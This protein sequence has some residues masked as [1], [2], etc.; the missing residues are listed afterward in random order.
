MDSGGSLKYFS[1]DDC[2]HREYKRWKQWA[3][4]KILVMDRLPKEARGA[5]IWTL[6]QGK[7]LEVVEHLTPDQYQV[8][9]GE[10]V[11]FDLLDARWPQKDKSDEIGEIIAEIFTMKGKD[12]ETLRQWSARARE[13]FDRCRRKCGVD[14][15]EEVRGWVLLNCSGLTEHERAVVLARGQGNLKFDAVSQAM[16]SCF[17]EYVIS[18]RKAAGVH[19]VEEMPDEFDQQA[20]S[21]NAVAGFEDVELLLAEHGL[22]DEHASSSLGP[23]EEWEESEA[24]EVL[25]ASWKNKR[26]ELSK[27]QKSRRF[28]QAN[29]LRRAFR[30]EVE[31]VKKR[32]KCFKCNKLGHFARECKAR[33]APSA[34]TAS[35]GTSGKDHA[36]GMVSVVTDEKEHF[37]C[38]AGYEL[39]SEHATCHD[40]CL[41]S[42][43]GFAVLDSGCGKT[44]V[45]EDTLH[46]FHCIWKAHGVRVPAE[47][48]ETNTFKFGNGEC[49]VSH[50]MIDM[51]VYIA[52]RRGVVRAAVVRGSAPLLLSRA[53]LKTLQA[54]MNFDRDELTLFGT[55][56][57]PMLVNEAGQYTVN[58]SK[59][60]GHSPI[61]ADSVAPRVLS[62][63]ASDDSDESHGVTL[64]CQPGTDAPPC[65]SVKVNK[66]RD[67][68]KD[69]WEVRP[70]DRLVVRH[71]V[72]PRRARFTPCH[73]QCPIDVKHLMS[74][75]VTH[76]MPMNDETEYQVCDQWTDSVD[77]HRIQHG[78]EWKGRTVFAIQPDA[79]LTCFEAFTENEVCLTQWTPKQHRQL[80]S[81]IRQGEVTKDVTKVNV[82]EV[83]S[84]PRFALECELRGLSCISADLC[85]GWDFRKQSDR[86]LMRDIVENR[87]PELLVLCPPCT[88]AGGWFHLNKERMS[89]EMVREKEVLTRL[90]IMFCK[91]LIEVQLRNGGRVLFE[92]PQDSVAWSMLLS[93]FPNMYVVDLHMCRYGL[94]IPGGDLIRKPTRLLV[95]HSDM[96][97]LSRKCPGNADP[98]HVQHQ[99]IAGSVPQVGSV[100]KF[101][102]KYP[103]AF[104]KSVLATVPEL[105]PQPVLVVQSDCS[106]ECLVAA[107]LDELNAEEGSQLRKSLLKL[108]SNLGHPPNQQLLRV[109]KHGGASPAALQAA[110]ELTCEQCVANAQ[111]KLPPPA[112]THRT[113][114][115]NSLV[116]IDVKYLT[117]WTTNQ[118]IPA[119]N[120]IDYASSLQVM[121]PLFKRETSELILN[122]FMER[123]VSW[124]GMPTE[125]VCDPAQPNVADALTVPLEENGAQIKIT[126]ANAHWQ[127]GKTEVH[128]GWFNRIFTKVINERVPKDQQEWLDCVHA[129]HCKNQLI[130]VY[131]MTPS[132]FVFGRNPRI[133]ENLMDEPLEVVPATASLYQEALAKQV[134]TRQA[135]RRAVLEL[136]DSRSLKLALAA[137]PRVTV[138][139]SPGQSVAYWRS[140][141]WV[142]GSLD[143]QGKWHGPAVVLG[144]VGRNYVIIHKKQIFRCAPEQIRAST[145][146]EQQLSQ[147]PHLELAGIKDLIDQG[148]INSRQYVDLLPESYPPG[149]GDRALPNPS[150]EP[151][152]MP[153]PEP[154]SVS[155]RQ[156]QSHVS[157][158]LPEPEV[159]DE[160]PMVDSVFD[161][162]P[163]VPMPPQVAAEADVSVFRG[164]SS[165]A[166]SS[167]EAA[168]YGPVRRK[169]LSKQGAPA[170]FRPGRMA[171]DDFSEMMQ[172]VVPQL[173]EQVL[174]SENTGR[175]ESSQSETRPAASKRSSSES[176]PES[177][178]S[179]KSQRT[180][181]P[182]RDQP[183]NDAL[184]IDHEGSTFACDEVTILSVEHCSS[185]STVEQLPRE[186]LTVS[187]AEELRT[188]LDNGEPIE[189][190]MASYMQKKSAKE[191]RSA[192]NPPELQ[193]KVDEAKLLEWNTILAKHAARLVL[194][195]E[196]EQVRKR[197]PNRIMG[198]RYVITIKQEDD[199]P[200]RVKAR[201]C[202]QGHLDPDLGVK[203][204][205]GDLQSPTLSQV[206][207]HMLFQLI[208]SKKWRLK[209]GDIKGAFLSAGD[210]PLKYRPLFARLPQGGIPGIPEDALIEVVGHVYGLNDSP[211]AWYR[212]LST[213]LLEA[214]F[215]KSRFDSCLFYMRENGELTGIYG[216]HVDDCATG[217]HGPKYQKAL[218]H[219]QE[220]FEFRKWRDGIEGGDF[221]G[222]SYTQDPISFEVHMSQSKFIQ[223]LRPIHFSKDRLRDKS[224]E[225]TPKEVSCLRAVNGS[226]NWLATQ[227]RPDL[228]TQV[229]FSQQSFPSPTVLDALAANHAVRRARQ[230]ADQNLRFSSIPVDKLSIMCHSDAAFANA[231]AGATQAGYMISFTHADM[232]VGAECSWSPIYWKSARLPRV[233]SSTLS[234][235]AQSMAVATSMCEWV[236]LLLSEALDGPRYVYNFWNHAS[237]RL[238]LVATDCKSL[239]DH[240]MSQSSPT[241]DDR[242]TAI[243][244]IIIRDCISRLGV[245]LR[246][247]PTDRMLADSLTK[248]SPEA[249]D[250]LR[251]CIRSA[252]YQIS[253]EQKILERRAEERERRRNFAQKSQLPEE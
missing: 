163:D 32:S 113:T 175:S 99:V 148:S 245:S 199:A 96:C 196:A 34:S 58:V 24:A 172:E 235:E 220:N 205:T 111:P 124:A 144:N 159:V 76:V 211:S 31:E 162:P 151:S 243:D 239:Y 16:R 188:M 27:L 123:W 147:T 121:V 46:D 23:D 150:A 1:G 185:P 174:R 19:V 90:F 103:T 64:H 218:K 132:Q 135:A 18:R 176:N 26:A 179:A 49:E 100:S 84:P 60:P 107:R 117:G 77:A 25:A 104:V 71:H 250:L 208:V 251:A 177:T 237:K 80:L 118:K 252:R 219:L 38:S 62:A 94:A 233:V 178:D 105:Q 56:T 224:A 101:A 52:G 10:K 212:K 45:G 40:V 8:E 155:D 129:S 68:V 69:Y 180:Q 93:H 130:Q 67:K 191:I 145:E 222:A 54:H 225:L 213:V 28:N 181:S 134:A 120:M 221:C 12:T 95:S 11:I 157:S 244:I 3:Q 158:E 102:G 14:F 4:N 167:E 182:A 217:G 247:L 153:Q 195:P 73:T 201:W 194:G 183:S 85:T 79:D 154:M 214:G 51:P 115:F 171:Q 43:P 141:K 234:A 75:R 128:G 86:S 156:Q 53:A 87:K 231:K 82:V 230:H 21:S 246:W 116:G 192:G 42:S 98:K 2:D 207:R 240:L 57:V 97:S 22:V 39:E 125:V 112:Q 248:E 160:S 50:R 200:E 133:P 227:S 5:F 9:G 66:H 249:F 206:A 13:A 138:A 30:V 253:P 142:H 65:H 70:K 126:A 6:L 74:H 223:K 190:L 184:V 36:A 106:H 241:L 166:K 55:E 229:S 127:L 44:I 33:G 72:K 139:M 48:A 210:L 47:R 81:Q 149:S 169:V 238:M 143:N 209:L 78:A 146:S 35:A 164:H 108:H 29:D 216:V 189:T 61:N 193:R 165:D 17:P 37:I 136:Q 168:S 202:L 173:L 63:D 186:N 89:P 187:E 232:D 228:A 140:Q 122:T 236:S 41:V 203:A 114:E 20:S 161:D 110:R 109:L 119:L 7:A 215:E 131:G 137:R 226:L 83:F 170:L 204:V 198:S 91:Q 197:M 92:H 59:F 152:D 15:P 242:R 88:W